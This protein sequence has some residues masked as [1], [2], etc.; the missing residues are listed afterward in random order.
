MWCGYYLF[1]ILFTFL[2]CLAFC[3]VFREIKTF[4]V[5]P[6]KPFN[7]N[8]VLCDVVLAFVELMI[9]K[10]VNDAL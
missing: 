4:F 7:L 3:P 10:F 8:F 5:D 6:G 1:Q 2:H 9:R